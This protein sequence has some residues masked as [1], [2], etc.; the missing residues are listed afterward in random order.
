[1]SK[2]GKVL[3]AIALA[4]G[5]LLVPT[6]SVG[7]SNG[8][9]NIINQIKNDTNFINS[10]MII[11]NSISSNDIKNNS[12]SSIDIKSGSIKRSDLAPDAIAMRAYGRIVDGRVV[13]KASRNIAVRMV[14]A[15]LCVSVADVDD[16]SALA[17]QLSGL[18]GES[19]P[20]FLELD[21]SACRAS[22]FAVGVYAPGEPFNFTILVP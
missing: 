13:Q 3:I 7:T 8:S 10:N 9:Y 5:V 6:L 16:A 15:Q 21:S 11:N 19:S 12:I 14:G 1:M 20:P 17:P 4:A 18:V 22:E 2:R